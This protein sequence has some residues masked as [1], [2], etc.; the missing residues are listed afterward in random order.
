VQANPL[1][2]QVPP[3]SLSPDKSKP[4]PSCRWLPF[5]GG[6]ALDSNEDPK[7]WK[8]LHNQYTLAAI[9]HGSADWNYRG[10]NFT[11]APGSIYVCEPGEVHRTTRVYCPGDFTAFF[12]DEHTLPTIGQQLGLGENLHFTPGGVSHPDLWGMFTHFHGLLTSSDVEA[13]EQ[14]MSRLL[15]SIARQSS[16]PRAMRGADERLGTSELLLQRTRARLE[17]TFRANPSR[18]IR[19]RAIALDMGVAYHSLIH[20]F[21]KRF[22][23]APYEYVDALRARVAFSAIR[24]GPT[25]HCASLTAVALASGYSDGPHMSRVFKKH[26]NLSP[27]ALARQLNP[28]W[29]AQRSNPPPRSSLR[30]TSTSP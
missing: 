30:A 26:W 27:S 17:E 16:A 9:R 25:A 24:R 8:V 19:L 7:P 4:A 1:R 21:S 23:L 6:V 28:K 2:G 20:D 3:L 12:L 11:V 5:E 29:E 15:V 14:A 18:T 22:G 13:R 10:K